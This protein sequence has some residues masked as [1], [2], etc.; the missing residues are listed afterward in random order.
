MPAI[1]PARLKQQAALVAEHFDNPV[2]FV[3]SLHHLLDF[4]A[5]RVKR[6]GQSG[7]PPPLLRAYNVRPPVL[8]QILQELLPLAE[9]DPQAGLALCE[10]L[11]EQ[12]YLEFGLLAAGLIGQI[13]PRPPEPV[14]ER[15]AAWLKSNP[16]QRLIVALLNQGLARLRQEDSQTLIALVESWLADENLF[17]RQLGLQALLPMVADLGFENLPA[18]YRLIQPLARSVPPLL[19]PDLLEVLAALAQR[20]P[21]ET[22]YFLRQSL[23]MPH[24][25]DTPWLIRQSLRAFPLEIQDSLRSAVRGIDRPLSRA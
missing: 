24:A 15:I 5:D 3:R 22:A 13:P 23:A 21:K 20:S 7:A 8:R 16:E 14:L 2:A 11:W 25:S 12:P 6:P 9:E 10:A 19:R 18:F 1:Q 4:Y 17:T